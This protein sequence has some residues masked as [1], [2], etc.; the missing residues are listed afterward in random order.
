M[1]DPSIPV[2]TPGL[3]SPFGML[4]FAEQYRRAGQIV[5]GSDERMSLYAPAYSMIGQ[6]IEL[7]L[8]AFL[9]ARRVPLDVLRHQ[10]GHRLEQLL[11]EALRRRITRLVPLL[12]FHI[13]AVR[14]L[15][16]AYARHEFR[17]IVTGSRS[18]PSWGFIAH[19][20]AELTRC[21]HD[22]LL[23]RRIGKVAAFQRT[24]LRGKF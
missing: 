9:L 14:L 21:Q 24:A 11:D 2:D 17:Y 8:K 16:P 3:T 23:R 13:Q 20:A 10:Y 22:W 15:A 6:S 12:D 5:I 1:T 19:T 4:R 7:S 18:L